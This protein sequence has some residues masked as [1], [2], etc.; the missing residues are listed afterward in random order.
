MELLERRDQP[1][2]VAHPDHVF[3]P[4]GGT[5]APL[6]SAGPTGTTP[7]QIRHAYGFDQLSFN[8]GATAADGTGTTIAIIDA[9]DDPNIANDLHQFDLRFGLPDP[10][11]QK[12]NQSGGSTMPASDPGWAS[13][14]ALDVE[15]AHA[16]APGAKILLVEAND[17]SY[18]NLFAAVTFAAKQQGV[19]AVSMSFGGDEFAGETS[20]DSTFHT[21]SGHGGVTFIASSGD[22]GAPTSYPAASPNVLS[23]GGT[24][25][26]LTSS[27]TILSESGWSGSGGGVSGFESQP[28]YQKGVVTQSS[29]SRTNPDV[30]YDAD[31]N[32]GFPVYDS[33]NNGNS[34]PWSQFGGTSDAAPQWAGLIAIADQGRA[35]NGLSSLD[36]PS[37]TIPMLYGLPAAD[38]HDITSGTSTG[39]P[40]LSAGPGYD[41]VTGRGTPV[42]NLII[43]ALAG[44]PTAPTATHFTVSTTTSTVAGNAFSVNVSAVDNNGNVITSFTGAVS[45]SSSDLIAGLPSSYTFTNADAGKHTFTVTLKTAGNQS[46][47]ATSGSLIGTSNNIAVSP[48]AASKLAFGQQPTN[49]TPATAIT[50]A[51]TV[52]ELDA[53]GNL[54][55]GDNT[56]QVTLTLGNA[57]G[58]TLSGTTTVT[59]SGGVATFSNLSI[60]NAGSGYM[61][62][63]SSGSLAGVT[64]SSFNI[65]TTPPSTGT[66]IE[67]FNPGESFNIA[68][69]RRINAVLG[70]YAAHDGTYGLDQY[71]GNQWIYRTDS[72]VQVKAGD[73]ITV[74]LQ[75]AGSAD[76][77]AY[78][79]FGASSRGTLSLVAAPN[80]GQLILQ[81]NSGFGFT[82]LASINQSYQANHWYKLEVDWSTTGAIVGKLLD[83]DGVTVLGTVSTTVSGITSGGIAFRAT[84][85]DKY[86]DTVTDTRGVNSFAISTGSTSGSSGSG[87]G[88]GSSTGGSCPGSTTP[89][90][91]SSGGSSAGSSSGSSSS[92]NPPPPSNPSDPWSWW[93]YYFGN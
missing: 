31:P 19:V 5:A 68:G 49:G 79:G 67:P 40:N 83:S 51:V 81:N 91:G 9:F 11:F 3:L 16:I 38:F 56:S 62:I 14:I 30:A 92:S 74:W 36:G 2:A 77:R 60:N 73:T 45:L 1:S 28:S 12:V 43:P 46:V 58:A 47:T 35:L 53:F 7:T 15:W 61:L 88:T 84:G 71:N 44:Q 42:A 54:E 70:T 37:Q 90:T 22:S 8:G 25:L 23:V 82:D 24:S 4:G 39:T 63:A 27:N 17:S 89:P 93:Q 69:G 50:P 6:S 13:E 65:T 34:F 75:F 64:S 32:T 80:T 87:T 72:S 18:T 21:P 41:L 86:W 76:G 29:T 26:R 48:A 20:L 78:F 85:S 10:V 66:V 52:R 59:V 57:N 33:F 55:T